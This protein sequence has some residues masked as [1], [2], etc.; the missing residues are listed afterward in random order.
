MLA[1]WMI[2]HEEM[3][4]A[5][6]VSTFAKFRPP[7]IYKDDYINLL[8]SYGHELRQACCGHQGCMLELCHELGCSKSTIDQDAGPAS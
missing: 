3:S 7:G 8:F 4:T 1:N 5:T 2:R 6:A